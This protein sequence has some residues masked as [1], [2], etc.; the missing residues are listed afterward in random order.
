MTSR[1]NGAIYC[2]KDAV[3]VCVVS[4]NS[5]KESCRAYP[6]VLE[7]DP[8]SAAENYKPSERQFLSPD[9]DGFS[10]HKTSSDHAARTPH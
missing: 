6:R 4:V 2:E 1:H 9:K 7:L 8:P 3:F 5:L 10:D